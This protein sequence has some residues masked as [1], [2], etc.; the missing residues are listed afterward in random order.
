MS[1]L[2]I[3][4]SEARD[5]VTVVAPEGRLDMDS[6][7]DLRDHVKQLV[8]T[9]VTRI[10]MDLSEIDFVDSS[11]LA[12]IISALRTVRQAGGTIHIARPSREVQLLLEITLL[13]QVIRPYPDIEGA[14]AD[15]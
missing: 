12:A 3:G 15:F 8:D 7:P 10:V 6:A 9:G 11:G 2:R 14:L 13:D 4:L 1:T 5:S